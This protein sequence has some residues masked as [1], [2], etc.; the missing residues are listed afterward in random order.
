MTEHFHDILSEKP[1][2]LEDL[3]RLDFLNQSIIDTARLLRNIG[4]GLQTA[5]EM[6]HGLQ[7]EATRAL[8]GLPSRPLSTSEDVEGDVQLF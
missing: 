2:A 3:Q 1:H 8:V 4:D 7:M 5:D 6:L